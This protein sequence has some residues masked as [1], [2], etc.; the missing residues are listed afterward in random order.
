[1]L[2]TTC[3][4]VAAGIIGETQAWTTV[5]ILCSSLGLNV[6]GFVFA[7]LRGISRYMWGQQVHWSPTAWIVLLAEF[8]MVPVLLGIT[9]FVQSRKTDFL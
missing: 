5:A 4:I 7:H 3:L 8:A 1:M 6:L 9:F 2:I